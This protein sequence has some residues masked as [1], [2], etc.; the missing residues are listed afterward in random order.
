MAQT[1]EAVFV[2][3]DPQLNLDHTP[4]SAVANGEV[5][6]LG[7]GLFGVCNTPEGIAA[8]ALGALATM[9]VWRFLKD[10]SAGPTFAVG[11]VIYWDASAG[12]AIPASS[13]GA[14]DYAIG[15]CVKAAGASDDGVWGI[16]NGAIAGGV[17]LGAG[18]RIVSGQHTTVAAAD[19]VVT[20]LNT[21]VSVVAVLDDDP[22]DGVMHVSATIGDQ[23]GT[24]A[25]G[26]VIIK[27]W[28]STDGDATLIAATTFG[29]KVNWIATGT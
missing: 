22:V 19:T 20:G 25:A 28:K 13:A 16:L 14:G 12:L 15:K 29:K 23:A 8:N 1:L 2:H 9:G 4:G 11:D 21:V 24:P 3:G 17:G 26:S 7:G 10:G 18:T 6:H 27:G 5:V